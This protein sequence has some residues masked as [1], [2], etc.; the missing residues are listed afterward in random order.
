MQTQGFTHSSSTVGYCNNILST[1]GT[2]LWVCFR[3]IPPHWTLVMWVALVL[4]YRLPSVHEIIYVIRIVEPISLLL[5]PQRSVNT[6]QTSLG[7]TR[8]VP[9]PSYFATITAFP[10][11]KR[12]YQVSIP[13]RH[14]LALWLSWF[15]KS[16]QSPGQTE[17]KFFQELLFVNRSNWSKCQSNLP[18]IW[19]G[20]GH[21]LDKSIDWERQSHSA[22]APYC[23]HRGIEKA[24]YIYCHA[25]L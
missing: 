1:Y 14:F 10:C 24:E 17:R 22:P 12:D 13:A 8:V 19:S 16:K 3:W 20:R 25:E 9:P 18:V 15:R 7:A 6:D 11:L 23:K 2:D 21:V 4:W 5:P